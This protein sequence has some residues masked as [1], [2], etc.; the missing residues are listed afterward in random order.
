MRERN[1]VLWLAAVSTS[2]SFGFDLVCGVCECVCMCMYL[3]VSAFLM[4]IDKKNFKFWVF[5]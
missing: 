5:F 2:V 4:K 3:F 1:F